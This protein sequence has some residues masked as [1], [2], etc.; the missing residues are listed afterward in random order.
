[1]IPIADE[2]FVH[3]QTPLMDNIRR[4]GIFLWTKTKFRP[5]SIKLMKN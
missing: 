1:L 3:R 4:E 2:D 5:I